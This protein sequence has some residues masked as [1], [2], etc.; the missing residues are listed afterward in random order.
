MRH[1]NHHQIR[2][3][4]IFKKPG[5]GHEWIPRDLRDDPRATCIHVG[6]RA[7]WTA[8]MGMEYMYYFRRVQQ[9]VG[10]MPAA[11]EPDAV[12]V[13]GIA[14]HTEARTVDAGDDGPPGSGLADKN[15]TLD[16]LMRAALG[17]SH[18]CITPRLH[19]AGRAASAA[20]AAPACCSDIAA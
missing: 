16:A 7:S 3:A 9:R 20:S 17:A 15:T 19:H 4:A 14:R 6:G 8:G 11:D 5:C 13:A 1:S 12:A 18:T 2:T 10:S